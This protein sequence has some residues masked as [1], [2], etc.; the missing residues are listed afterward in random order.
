MGDP[1]G[2]YVASSLPQQKILP[3]NL[4]LAITQTTFKEVCS[5]ILP[6]AGSGSPAG[7]AFDLSFYL[8]QLKCESVVTFVENACGVTLQPF[9]HPSQGQNVIH[10]QNW[11]YTVV[12]FTLLDVQRCVREAV[13]NGT[14]Q[15]QGPSPIT[16]R[17]TLDSA[18][19][20]NKPLY[21]V[22]MQCPAPGFEDV[23]RGGFAV[24]PNGDS[25]QVFGTSSFLRK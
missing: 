2:A 18:G 5:W 14:L 21:P 7:A 25:G 11:G 10:M 15:V 22:E 20:R 19:A 4:H 23:L 9:F 1:C 17:R 3:P 12:P 16:K 13:D 6:S 8:Q 24:S